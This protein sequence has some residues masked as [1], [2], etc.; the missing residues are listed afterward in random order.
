METNT[1]QRIPQNPQILQ[2]NARYALKTT[3]TTTRVVKSTK[4]YYKKE[5]QPHK[6]HT[7]TEHS[8]RMKTQ[9]QSN[10]NIL[11]LLPKVREAEELT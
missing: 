5:T 8:Q 11:K 1:I 6:N 9:L 10:N 2:L 7:G 3:H 4:K